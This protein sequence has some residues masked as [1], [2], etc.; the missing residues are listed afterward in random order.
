MTTPFDLII[1]DFDGVV[2]DSE[3][4][5]NTALA[6]YLTRHGK[7][8]S[9]DDAI[10]E[11]M[12]KRVEDVRIAAAAWLGRPLPESFVTDYR[13]ETRE[14]MRRDVTAIPGVHAFLD[15]HAHV[16][17]CVASSSMH[18]WLEHCVAKFD[19]GRHFDGRLT[20]ASEVAN[21]KPAPDVF[22]LAAAR[23]GVLPERT[24]V[25]EDSPAGITGARA[26]GMHTIGFLGGSHIRPGHA[27]RLSAAGADRLVDG[28]PALARYLADST[29]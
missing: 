25:I 10:R 19:L 21:G 4:L 14:M 7:P 16:A 23:M 11:F 9:L 15:A 2:V 5:A 12:G 18:G 22:L 28:Y 17:R 20:S 27:E 3:V 26:A 29:R 8:T 13:D 6:A 1:F 24:L